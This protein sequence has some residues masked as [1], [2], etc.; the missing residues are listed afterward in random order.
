MIYLD[1]AATTF[2]KPEAV[3]DT[4]EYWQREACVNAG[5]GGYKSARQASDIIADTRSKIAGYVGAALAEDVIFTSSATMAANVVLQGLSLTEGDVVYVSPYEHNAIMRTLHALEQRKGIVVRV[6]PVCADGRLDMEGAHA[7]FEKELPR[8]V[9]VTQ[10]SNVTGY[11]LPYYELFTLAKKY[12]AIT[13]LDSAQGLGVLPVHV[14]EEK[15]DFLLFAGH[16][17]LY[18]TFGVGGFV[19]GSGMD[20]DPVILGGNGSDSLNLELPEKGIERYEIGSP[21]LPAIAALGKAVELVASDHE[22]RLE[23]ERQLL[24]GLQEK[25]Q[26]IAGVEVF[27]SEL[28]TD[29]RVGIL[30]FAC[31]RYTS[32][33]LGMIL[34][35]DF[36]I[37]V[38]TGYHCA[39]LVHDVIGSKKYGGTVRVG[40]SMFTVEKEVDALVEAVKELMEE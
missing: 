39:P 22:K 32:E 31:E 18:G 1:N 36:D 20:L 9:C 16:K 33:D 7:S 14:L 6:L 37:A 4:Y 13:L 2:P 21:N 29:E 11:C 26:E 34:D 28:G 8:L 5:R 27:A 23:H 35:E 3:W 12:D 17:N 30:S 10:V 38:R 24:C 25:L 15:I 19:N 40:V